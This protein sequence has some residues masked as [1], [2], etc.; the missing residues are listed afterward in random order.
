MF[1]ESLIVNVHKK[2]NVLIWW[3]TREETPLPIPNREVKLSRADDTPCGESRQSPV[4]SIEKSPKGDFLFT[5]TSSFLGY[6]LDMSKWSSKRKGKILLAIGAL[7]VLAIIF[8]FIQYENAK[9]PTCFDGIQNG[10]ESGIDC[11]GTCA[12]QCK[13]ESNNLVVWWERPFEVTNGIYNVVA[14]FENQNLF[15]G[16]RELE[17]EFRLYD[18]DNILVTAPVRGTTF[19]EANKRS[20]IFEPGIQVGDKD[21][22]TTFFKIL[23]D[24]DFEKVDADFAYN[25]FTVTEP[26]LSQLDTA[27]KLSANVTNDSFMTFR[28][29]PVTVALYDIENNALAASRTYIDEIKQGETE[30]IFYSWPEIF[31]GGTGVAR[32]EILPRV[33]PFT[34][35]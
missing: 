4:Q 5:R 3:F 20:T 26:T 29:V 13:V 9:V 28:D 27:P 16:V 2:F 17:Y 34:V 33:N 24:P 30:K 21:V 23:N 7:I 10:G 22:Y 25:L 1:P 14:Y 15:S 35:Q 11:G 19:V 32:I 6:T 8:A 31:E 12:L 18:K